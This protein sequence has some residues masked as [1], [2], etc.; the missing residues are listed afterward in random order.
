VDFLET[1]PSE[2]NHCAEVA[3]GALYLALNDA[4]RKAGEPSH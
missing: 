2:E 3:V 4:R 1:L